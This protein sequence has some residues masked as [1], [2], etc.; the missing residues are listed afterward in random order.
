MNPGR[1]LV[2]AHT[3]QP[4]GVSEGFTAAQMVSALRQRG[5]RMIVL[6][7]KLERLALGFGELG[8]RCRTEAETPFIT[9]Q[10]YLEFAVRSVFL[11]RRIRERISLVHH[12]TPI[13]IRLPSFGAGIG[14]PFIWGPVGGSVPYPPGFARYG[15]PNNLANAVR[16]LDRPRMHLDPTIRA[17]LRSADRIIVTT[18]MTATMIPDAYRDKLLVIP[19]GI[20]GELLL[21]EPAAEQPYVFSS[22]RLV[23]YKAMDL[24]IRAFALVRSPDVK[25]IISGDGPNKTEL[26]ALIERL[27]LRERVEMLG[28]VARERNQEFMR[29]SLFCV[30]PAIRE[31]FGHVNLEAMAAW[32][33]VIATDWGGPRDLIV[34]GTTG[35]KVLGRDPDE[36]VELIADAIQRLLG[37]S[38][39]RRRMGANGAAFAK[40]KYCW[41]VLA[42][43]YDDIYRELSP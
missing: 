16:L 40:A 30:F 3:Y 2:L 14:L 19:E 28:R 27:G 24:L 31:A 36:H 6:T 18:S 20:P 25:L 37:D 1:I 13:S 17:T 12:V 43:R 5:R 11:G 42:S 38:E 21:S 9:A 22:G 29:R 7:A 15:H 34:D 26:L 10:N 35:I 23:D 4:Q 32:K 39:L 41:P 8:V 33:P